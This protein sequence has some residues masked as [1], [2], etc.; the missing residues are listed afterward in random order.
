LSH[1]QVTDVAAGSRLSR[2]LSCT[3]G[4]RAR[5]PHFG[6]RLPPP[7]YRETFW[8]FPQQFRLRAPG[9]RIR[10]AWRPIIGSGG[11]KSPLAWG[12]T[13]ALRTTVYVV[14]PHS[15][16]AKF[17]AWDCK[18]T[19]VHCTCQEGNTICCIPSND[20]LGAGLRPG[21]PHRAREGVSV[22]GESGQI[23]GCLEP[24]NKVCGSGKFTHGRSVKEEAGRGNR[25]L[26]VGC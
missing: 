23:Q 17:P 22:D 9:L 19:P 10:R 5:P 21:F 11:A 7:G 16:E 6:F 2:S 24:G 3:G 18:V 8:P 4:G 14:S 1:E 25:K 26:S 20:G 13:A 12:R 15:R